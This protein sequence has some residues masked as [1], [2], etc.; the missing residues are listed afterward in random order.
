L[1]DRCPGR[2]SATYYQVADCKTDCGSQNVDCNDQAANAG[3]PNGPDSAIVGLTPPLGKC[4]SLSFGPAPPKGTCACVPQSSCAQF[5]N[6]LRVGSLS[7]VRGR[8]RLAGHAKSVNLAEQILGLDGFP[9]VAVHAT[10]Q[11]LL[12]VAWHR[13]GGQRND[14]DMSAP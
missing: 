6:F 2:N 5:M 9:D 14:G 1:A 7:R 11:A 8:D 10:S 4:H 12:L 3:S 13:Q